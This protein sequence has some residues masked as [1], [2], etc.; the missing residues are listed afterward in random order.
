MDILSWYKRRISD[1]ISDIQEMMKSAGFDLPLAEAWQT[2]FSPLVSI[3]SPIKS[4]HEKVSASNFGVQPENIVE[5]LYTHLDERQWQQMRER[6]FSNHL[7]IFSFQSDREL[8]IWYTPA[9]DKVSRVPIAPSVSIMGLKGDD[10]G[11]PNLVARMFDLTVFESLR[12]QVAS[13]QSI[14]C[15]LRHQYGGDC[16][17]RAGLI[18]SIYEA[19][20]KAMDIKELGWKPTKW[21]EPECSKT[22]IK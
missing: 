18:W 1:G 7:A 2:D 14:N 17:G 9:C 21:D 19:G 13:G 22:N 8:G 16:C 5:R 15:F 12:E 6:I 11:T 3:T 4:S 20:R 10:G